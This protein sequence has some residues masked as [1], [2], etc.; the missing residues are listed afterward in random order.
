MSSVSPAGVLTLNESALELLW[1]TYSD[2]SGTISSLDYVGSSADALDYGQSLAGLV[3]YRG[4]I[5]DDD[6]P[7]E[8]AYVSISAN[9]TGSSGATGLSGSAAAD[10]I[11]ASTG[12]AKTGDIEKDND[13]SGYDAFSLTLHNDDD[14]IWWVNLFINTGYTTGGYGEPDNY[15][16]NGWVMLPGLSSATLTVD[17]TDPTI[18]HLNHVTDIGICIGGEMNGSPYGVPANPSNPDVYHIS[19][20]PIP[21]P[22]TLAMLALGSLAFLGRRKA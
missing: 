20:S 4:R 19:A 11:A 12:V 21:E 22:A 8:F 10:L 16:E 6:G 13:L 5:Q 18:Q 3:G 9:L 17:F 1:H 2:P 15:Y 7:S 14:D